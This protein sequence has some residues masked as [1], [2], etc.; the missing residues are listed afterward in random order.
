MRNRNS[1]SIRH[2][3]QKGK[4]LFTAVIRYSFVTL[5]RG[6]NEIII[7]VKFTVCTLRNMILAQIV[8]RKIIPRNVPLFNVI[9]N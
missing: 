9:I 4:K 5:E 8:L 1:A 2:H 7:Q 6:S 3:V